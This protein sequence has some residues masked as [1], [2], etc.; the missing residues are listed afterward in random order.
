MVSTFSLVV[1][2]LCYY[3]FQKSCIHRMVRLLLCFCLSF[4]KDPQYVW[5]RHSFRHLDL[6]MH[7]SGGPITHHLMAF[8][9]QSHWVLYNYYCIRLHSKQHH[10]SLWQT[11]TTQ[12]DRLQPSAVSATTVLGGCST[13]SKFLGRLLGK[14]VNHTQ[15]HEQYL[16][17]YHNSHIDYLRDCRHIIINHYV[18]L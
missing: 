5:M 14:M 8:T 12:C 1:V 7:K 9:E 16:L 4:S 2:A 6:H 17:I 11:T 13:T 18:K 3:S 15:L 10:Q